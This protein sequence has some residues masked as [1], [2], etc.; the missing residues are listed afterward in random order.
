MS[1]IGD[2]TGAPRGL[3]RRR[4]ATTEAVGEHIQVTFRFGRDLEV[5]YLERPPSPGDRVLHDG[6]PWV[7]TSV[8]SDSAGPVVS[9]RRARDVVR[10][11]RVTP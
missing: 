8:G 2:P 6:K 1:R 9:S 3:N 11:A 4:S 7:V 10:A 5:R